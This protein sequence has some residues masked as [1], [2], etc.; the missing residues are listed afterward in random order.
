MMAL[1]LA[2][3]NT[4]T[5]KKRKNNSTIVSLGLI[6]GL[7]ALLAFSPGQKPSARIMFYNVENLFDTIDNPDKSD[8]EF[9][10]DGVRNWGGYRF[11]IKLQRLSQVIV[12]AGENGF[13]AVIGMCEIE[14]QQVLESLIHF[15]PLKKINYGI[16][17]HESPDSRGID[18]AMLYRKDMFL[19]HFYRA[20]KVSDPADPS[21]TTRDIL[22]VKGLLGTD[23]MHFF[24]NHWPSKYGGVSATKPRRALAAS[25]LRAQTDSLLACNPLANIVIMGDLN[26]SPSDKSVVEVLGAK[27]VGKPSPSGLYNLAYPLAK[28]GIGTN[29]YRSK[30]DLI[31][32]F[33]VSRNLVSKGGMA[34]HPDAFSVFSPSYL[35]VKDENNLG[36]KLNRT[37][38]GVK[39]NGGFSDHLPILLDLRKK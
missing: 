38:V 28:K 29:K 37:F 6:V 26:D 22:Y 32:Q 5:L 8:E 31:D 10:P 30:W 24:V 9:L 15:T 12:A 14:N 20:I 19:P 35:L 33:I 4:S 36:E 34:S 17:H 7:F 27:P 21:F 2:P 3:M 11:Y 13:P 39:Y 25:V 16:V 23:T 1:I 18:V